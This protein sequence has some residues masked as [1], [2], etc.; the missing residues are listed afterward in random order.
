MQ[1]IFETL[2]D[3]VYL[4]GVILAGLI[5]AIKGTSPLVKKFGIMAALLGAGDSFHLVPRAYALWTNGLEAN[6][7]ALGFGKLVTS[8]TMTV[9][10]LI[11]YYI[12]RERYQIGGKKGITAA[13]W[14]LAVLRVALC[15]LPQN[16]WLSYRQP[17]LF[18]V[19]RN[20]P[21]AVMGLIIILL[22]WR[23]SKRAQDKIFRFMPLAIG[24]SFGF[25]IPVVLFSAVFPLVGML[26]IPKTVAYAWIVLMG[27]RLY[28]ANLP[29]SGKSP[30]KGG[31][32]DR[33][34]MG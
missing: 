16:D 3:V 15:L 12:W 24:L 28:T 29:Q 2:F 33:V 13:I 1:A 20:L 10:Y 19:L 22:F 25:Y 18:G 6:A 5:M 32:T 34:R 27:W 17:L 31:K 11:L 23:E 9:F 14:G 21:F 8:I 7:A 26:M 30:P 4:V